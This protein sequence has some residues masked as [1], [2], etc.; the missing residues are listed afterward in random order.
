[1]ESTDGPHQS[2]Y[3]ASLFDQINLGT[4]LGRV[5]AR[6]AAP[7]ALVHQRLARCYFCAPFIRW[8]NVRR[9]MDRMVWILSIDGSTKNTRKGRAPLDQKPTRL[10][11][12][13]L[14][15]HHAR[16]L[17][18]GPTLVKVCLCI[19][20]CVYMRVCVP[21]S[22][23]HQHPKAHKPTLSFSGLKPASRHHSLLAPAPASSSASRR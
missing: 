14:H 13:V 20:V 19:Y 16:Q 23:T 11:G 15:E 17:V 22:K 10:L 3:T 21:H 2:T 5:P 6:L 18:A 4:D 8:K 7:P 1:M 12:R 9:S